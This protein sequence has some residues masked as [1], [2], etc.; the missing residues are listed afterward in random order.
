MEDRL[1]GEV[2]IEHKTNSAQLETADRSEKK[3]CIPRLFLN[4]YYERV[5][6]IGLCNSQHSYL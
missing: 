2:E 1:H 3:R 4:V 5:D 6:N